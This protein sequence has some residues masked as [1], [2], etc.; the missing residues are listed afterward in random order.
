MNIKEYEKIIKHNYQ[1]L[2]YVSSYTAKDPDKPYFA[3]NLKSLKDAILQLE[4]IDLIKEDIDILKNSSL[5]SNNK[6]EDYFNSLQNSLIDLSTKRL[7]IGLHFLL[8]YREQNP[9]PELGLFV[10]LPEI[11]NFDDL[12]KA[13]NDFK[14]ALEMP[15]N[16][17]QDGGYVKIETAE[18]GS[19]WL[20]LSVGAMSAVN[21]IGAIC[22]AAAVIRKKKAEAKIFE[23]HT[24]TLELKNDSLQ[25][26]VEAQKQQLKNILQGEAEAIAKNHYSSNDP[27]VI[28]RLKLSISTV[29]DLIDRGSQILP[30]SD[31]VETLKSFPDYTKLHL[32][33]STIKKLQNEN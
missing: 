31:N 12:A 6:D 25:I 33:E 17:Q 29:S 21:L 2:I 16:D 19:I 28:S 4:D 18:P 3:K 10:R 22:W 9:S 30:S 15:I 13:S 1:K 23:E 32:I 14:K 11:Q 26:F 8:K 27:E 7:N 5:F 20:I 24:R